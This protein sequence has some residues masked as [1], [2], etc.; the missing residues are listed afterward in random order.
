VLSLERL[1]IRAAFFRSIRSFFFDRG[2]LEVDTPLRQPVLIPESNI[3]PLASEGQYLQ[4]SP[5]LCMK[6]LLALGCD[7]IF[8]ISHCFRKGELGRLHLEEFQLLE[9]YRTDCDYR[10]LMTDCQEL[11]RF[12]VPCLNT[13]AVASGMSSTAFFFAGIDF[14]APWQRITVAEAFARF[15]P[16]PL[17]MALDNGNFDE[18]LTEFVEPQLGLKVPAFLYD[19]PCRLASLARKS[20]ADPAIA[21]RFELYMQGVEI[22]N[23]FSELTDP[24]E[25]RA[26]FEKEIAEIDENT[27][28]KADMPV[29]FLEDLESLQEAAG[30]ALGLDRLFMLAI[31]AGSLN[32]AV[33]FSPTD[34]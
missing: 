16:V 8:Q 33:T 30:I 1:H 32:A 27:G 14:N 13:F 24:L 3:V 19:Y 18:I 29:R 11:L 2:F 17:E 25:Q 31:N 22:A 6:R 4:T 12:L 7:K 5:E 26:R 10:H 20:P 9:W 34:L 15:S 28:R 21:E 23:G